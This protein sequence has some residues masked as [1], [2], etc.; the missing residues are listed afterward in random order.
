MLTTI[1]PCQRPG[2]FYVL[3]NGFKFDFPSFIASALKKY[4]EKM[5]LNK[6]DINVG[7]WVLSLPIKERMEV[8]IQLTNDRIKKKY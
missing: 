4:L 7:N 2:R 6:S 3:E 8:N 1:Y 5:E